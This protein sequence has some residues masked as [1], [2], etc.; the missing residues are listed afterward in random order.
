[1]TLACAGLLEPKGSGLRLLKFTFNAENFICRLSW[2]I[3]SHFGA[4]HSGNA[5]RSSTSRKIYEKA[6]ILGVQ[7]QSS[8]SMLTFLRSSSPVLVIISSMFVAICNH[9]YVRRANNGGITPFR[10]RL[11]F[12]PSFVGTPFTHWYEILSQN[13]RDSKLSYG[14]N[15]KFLFH[16]DSYRY[17]VVS[18][19]CD[20]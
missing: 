3:C 14:E 19:S 15:Q 16:P 7:S 5:C 10:G 17:R 2:S 13:T 11:C 4:I 12:S 18:V 6:P 9:F 8:S 20:F 1:M